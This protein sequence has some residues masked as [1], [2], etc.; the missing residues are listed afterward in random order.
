[1]I[2]R[3]PRNRISLSILGAFFVFAGFATLIQEQSVLKF[4]ILAGTGAFMFWMASREK[5]K[6]R[7]TS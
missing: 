7:P 1:M 6:P 3:I 2:V 5:R 4:S